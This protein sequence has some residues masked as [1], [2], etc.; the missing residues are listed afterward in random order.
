MVSSMNQKNV[1]GI[2]LWLSLVCL[3]VF[4]MVIVGG[5][6]RLTHSGLSIVEWKPLMGAIP[7]MGEAG[8]NE[9]FE[10]YKQFPEYQKVNNQ[11][12]L[13]E[14]KYIF[15]WEYF[16]RLLGRLIGVVFFFPFLY[17]AIR[18]EIGAA[19]MK[20]LSL[21]FILGG[22]Q[23]LMG[24][25]MVKSGLV[26]MPS[27]S[28]YRLAAHLMLAFTIFAYILWIILD[29]IS[30]KKAKPES[31]TKNSMFSF[32]V[33]V[34]GLIV[35]QIIF[36]AF[37]A[38]KKAGLNYN[39]FPKMNDSWIAP[40]VFEMTPLIINFFENNAGIQFAHRMIAW[41]VVLALAY[42][43]HRA[44]RSARSKKLK[45][46]VYLLSGTLVLQFTLGV[47]TLLLQAPVYMAAIH[48]A[49]AFIFFG[50]AIFVNHSMLH[51]VD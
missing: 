8:W 16:H 33:F 1:N 50:S 38:G 22:L 45:M 35:L 18:K 21:A 3:M 4:G 34:T 32:S 20:R 37:T 31:G 15:Y 40:E 12:T 28:H 43:G 23:G 13:D 7:P 19:L 27:V 46:A 41:I 9:V 10:K 51:D 36:G 14:F 11:M 42:F 6:T 29:L 49:G 44:A 25:Y 30:D 48:Q 24:W 26:D 47:I 39:T 2:I 5:I 17:F